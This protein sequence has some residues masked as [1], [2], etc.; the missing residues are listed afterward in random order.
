M[1]AAL[2]N[3]STIDEFEE[4]YERAEEVHLLF[5]RTRFDLL[6]HIQRHGCTTIESLERKIA[7]ATF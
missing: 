2:D 5:V 3:V 1:L 6:I 4:A 7:A